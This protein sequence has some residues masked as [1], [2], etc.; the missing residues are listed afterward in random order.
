MSAT[1]LCIPISGLIGTVGHVEAAKESVL[2][3][4]F[5]QT[6]DSLN[7]MIGLS[8]AAYVFYGLV[9]DALHAVG[10]DFE[11][12]GN[13]A[14]DTRIVPATDPEL[15]T[16]GEPYGSV[17]EFDISLNTTWH[18]REPLSVEDVI[19]SI[20]LNCEGDN[21]IT[22]W[23]YQPYAY[24]M[25]YAKRVDDDTIR[26]HFYNRD[27]GESIPAAYP[28]LIC[29]PILPKHM[30]EQMT[31]YDISFKWNGVFPGHDPPIV[32][33]G[34]FK[35]T[36]N[37][38]QEWLDGNYLTLER[39]PDYHWKV[40]MG[41]VVQFD[42]LRMY[43]YDEASAMRLALENGELD[44]AQF[45]PHEF[46][47]IENA[48]K[49]G[50]LRN[51]TTFAG[52][53]CTQYWTEIGINMNQGGGPNPSR[54]DPAI[55]KAM[56]MATNKTYIV[57][58]YYFGYAEEGSTLISPVNKEWH[59]EPTEAEKIKFDI[60]AAKDLLTNAGYI[61]TN[62]DRLR[63]ATSSS[64][65]VREGLVAEGTP[66]KYEM[67]IRREYPEEKD[68]ADYL[69]QQWRE[70]GID[71][72][73]RVMN[74]PALATEA[75]TYSYDTLIWYWSADPD[76]NFML[77]CQSKKSWNG[78]S[79][80]M[81]YN[82]DYEENYT[83]SVSA[84]DPVE[85]KMYTDNCQRISYEDAAYILLA[86]A[87]QTYAWRNDTFENWGDWAAHPARSFDAFWF[88]NPL[89][90][91]LKPLGAVEHEGPPVVLLAI[92]AGA[93]VAVV[94]AV[95]LLSRMRKKKGVGGEG[96]LGD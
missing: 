34:P 73:Y 6:V 45:P 5:M 60:E 37:I 21:Y 67:M 81:Y 51:V 10:E 17:W 94:A 3:V 31:A 87:Y 40:E 50:T 84:L 1:V 27:T 13:L 96:P 7:P 36:K 65:A 24:F 14:T 76:P 52:L 32:G 72:E 25:K 75:Y 92:G 91:D 70:I 18:D 80:N 89:F 85:R 38:Y 46:R 11:T 86:Y 69:D 12:V 74:E 19:Y 68:I 90:F 44:L 4:G 56:A 58:R 62:G 53:K 93:V 8:D 26:I 49:A 63:E 16:S 39:N 20:N 35:A 23:A 41:K 48:V 88:G 83:K 57:E 9:Y 79:D 28:N 22:M 66:L 61:D 77:F 64:W 71:I 78:W 15:I 82:P 30:L 2:R 59:Y 54:V 55:R 43:F 95:V 47:S 33:T 29:I 42:K